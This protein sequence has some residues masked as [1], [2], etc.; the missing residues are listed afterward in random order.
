M[1]SRHT[2]AIMLNPTAC[3]QLQLPFSTCRRGSAPNLTPYFCPCSCWVPLSQRTVSRPSTYLRTSW[4]TYMNAAS[5]Y[6]MNTGD[7][8]D[9]MFY[10]Q[11]QPL[12]APCHFHIHLYIFATVCMNLQACVHALSAYACKD[13]PVMVLQIWNIFVCNSILI[14]SQHLLLLLTHRV[15]TH[16]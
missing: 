4:Y 8:H 5:E 9:Y 6:G 7:H 13:I 11:K 1:E 10:L 2:G 14:W 12:Q 15:R 16:S 3:L